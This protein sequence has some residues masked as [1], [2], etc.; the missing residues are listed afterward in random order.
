MLCAVSNLI[1]IC[2]A[3]GADVPG[4]DN[5]PSSVLH[6]ELVNSHHKND[7]PAITTEQKA[8]LQNSLQNLI[9]HSADKDDLSRHLADGD[10]EFINEFLETF[11][12]DIPIGESINFLGVN[13]VI[14][15]IRCDSFEISDIDIKGSNASQDVRLSFFVTGIDLSCTL[16]YSYSG[17][18]LIGRGDGTIDLDINPDTSI[19]T[20]ITF[21]SPDFDTKPP[22]DADLACT[23]Q[24]EIER[25]EFGSFLLDKVVAPALPGILGPLIEPLICQP[26]QSLETMLADIL[27]MISEEINEFSGTLTPEQTDNLYPEKQLNASSSSNF[28]DLTL[29][30]PIIETLTNPLENLL[31]GLVTDIIFGNNNGTISI[32]IAVPLVDNIDLVEIRILGFN[33]LNLDFISVIGKYTMESSFALD[34]VGIEID[35]ALTTDGTT[36]MFTV[37]TA[38]NDLEFNMA[39]MLVIEQNLNIQTILTNFDNILNC[40]SDS[41]F[42]LEVAGL[43]VTTGDLEAI[44]ISDLSLVGPQNL[45]NEISQAITFMYGVIL[46]NAITF[47]FESTVRDEINSS[48]ISSSNTCVEE[49]YGRTIYVPVSFSCWK[50]ELFDFGVVAIDYSDYDCSNEFHNA[51]TILSTY[52]YTAWTENKAFFIEGEDSYWN[53]QIEFIEDPSVS[54]IQVEDNMSDEEELFDLVLTFPTCTKPCSS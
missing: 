47:F 5:T 19:K 41:L 43:Y 54:E 51:T 23:A 35:L 8:I 13:F 15:G 33:D 2:S 10:W 40:I 50:I 31:E 22:L 45:V 6:K 39:I 3:S 24:L 21:N 30:S 36:D 9:L 12:L 49:F 48:I 32:P 14:E 46:K 44:Q 11:D 28:L 4:A 42:A 26:L 16:E 38:L 7:I 17:G 18:F 27:V 1:E 25:I 37:T 20:A 52:D 34:R 53:G 29:F